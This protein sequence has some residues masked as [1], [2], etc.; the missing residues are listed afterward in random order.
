MS[1]TSLTEC[2][3]VDLMTLSQTNV[4]TQ[5]SRP[6]RRGKE[7]WQF[8]VTV[9]DDKGGSG[10]SFPLGIREWQDWQFDITVTDEVFQV[11]FLFH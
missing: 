5:K 3:S 11:V 2:L 1:L 4:R 8:D 9:T 7:D 6:L 10:A